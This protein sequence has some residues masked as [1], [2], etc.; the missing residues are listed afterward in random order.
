M[1]IK[2][3]KLEADRKMIGEGGAFQI[4]TLAPRS[5]IPLAIALTAGEGCFWAFHWV[6]VMRSCSLG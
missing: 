6:F 4:V 3:M 2:K 5:G 1:K